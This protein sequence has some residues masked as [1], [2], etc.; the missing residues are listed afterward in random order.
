LWDGA[1]TGYYIDGY[2]LVGTLTLND[3]PAVATNP[4]TSGYMIA[5]AKNG[6]QSTSFTCAYTIG[7][8]QTMTTNTNIGTYTSNSGT[9]TTAASFNT[10][11]TG[12]TNVPAQLIVDPAASGSIF[13]KSACTFNDGTNGCWGQTFTY[14]A[15]KSV[16]QIWY[17]MQKQTA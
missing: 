15:K 16:W 12:S 8:A 13:T 14:A 10:L 7:S 5:C 17:Y 6:F 1:G 3:D 9:L 4:V 11:Q 2:A